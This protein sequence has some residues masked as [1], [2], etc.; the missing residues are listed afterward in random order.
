MEKDLE[1]LCDK[2]CQNKILIEKMM[3]YSLKEGYTINEAAKCIEKYFNTKGMQQ[4]MQQENF[5]KYKEDK[6]KRGKLLPVKSR[7]F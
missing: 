2:F 6:N 4:S 1:L 5:L 3:E 7:R